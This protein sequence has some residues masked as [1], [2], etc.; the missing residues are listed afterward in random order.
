MTNKDTSIY[1]KFH[2]IHK[3]AQKPRI[4]GNQTNFAYKKPR[5]I[6][7]N[8]QMNDKPNQSKQTNHAFCMPN[9]YQRE[10][11]E[12]LK[13]AKKPQKGQNPKNGQKSPK[14]TKISTKFQKVS[15]KF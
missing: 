12:T 1:M 9:V 14:F 4:P 7:E 8:L 13:K 5:K 3:K 15:T 10:I 11:P 2:K 6:Y